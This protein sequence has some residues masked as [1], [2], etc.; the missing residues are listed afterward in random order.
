MKL[1]LCLYLPLTSE[2]RGGS[3]K[4]YFTTTQP[5]VYRNYADVV[6][7]VQSIQGRKCNCALFT[8]H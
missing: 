5:A 2:S 4:K 3:T 7:G 1:L 6:G 8:V